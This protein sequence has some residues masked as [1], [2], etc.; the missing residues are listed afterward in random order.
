MKRHLLS[1]AALAA[2]LFAPQLVSAQDAEFANQEYLIVNFATGKY[3]GA[4]NSWGTQ[5]SLVEHPEY[6]KLVPQ[7][8]GTYYLESQVSN[9]GTAHYF[10]GDFMDNDQPKALTIKKHEEPI[11]YLDDAETVPYYGYTISNGTN[12]YGWDGTSTV[13]GKNLN[14]STEEGLSSALWVII[15]L[16]DAKAGLVKASVKEPVDATFLIYD[17][18]FGRNNRWG[19]ELSTHNDQVKNADLGAAW[20]FN[21]S[22]KN[23]AGDATNYCVESWHANFT[24][25]QELKNIPAGVYALTAQGFYRQDGSNDTDL[26]VFYANDATAT[27]PFKTGTENSMDDASHSFSKGLYTID[28]IFVE[29]KDGEALTIGAKLENNTTLWCIWDNFVLTY[30]GACTIEEAKNAATFAQ[31]EEL[32][33]TL[34]GLTGNVE[35]AT[36]KTELQGILDTIDPDEIVTLDDAKKAIDELNVAINK[37]KAYIAMKDKLAQVKAAI[38]TTNFY[39]PEAY[40]ANYTDVLAKYQAGTLTTE[41][42]DNYDPGSREA[43]A[44]PAILLSAWDGFYMNTWSTEGVPGAWNYNGVEFPCPF[45]EYWVADD[46]SLGAKTFTGTMNNIPAGFYNVTL[47]ARVRMKN[48][49]EAPATGIT[50]QVNEGEKI[51][52]CAGD[53]IGSGPFYQKE[54]TATGEVG[55]DGVLKVKIDVADGN[56]ISWLA[57]EKVNYAEAVFDI[58]ISPK[59]GDIA[60]ALTAAA[61]G[62]KVGN[63]TVNLTQGETYTLSS[64]I[65]AAANVIINGNGATINASTLSAP[66]IS[67]KSIEGDFA[68]KNETTPSA[69]VIVNKILIEGVT[70]TGLANSIIDNASG[71]KTLFKEVLLNN[72][73]IELSGSKNVFAL[74]TAYATN[75][76]IKNSTLWSKDGH[77][78]FFFKAD[79]KPADVNAEETTTWAIESSTLYNIAVGKKANNSNGGIKGKKTTYMSITNSLLYNFGSSTG[80]EVNGWLWGQNGGANATYANNAYLNADGVVAGWTDEAKGGSDQ[81]GTSVAGIVT[82]TDAAAGNFNGT[83]E[84][85]EGAEAPQELGDPR[86]KFNITTG[87]QTV[88]TTMENGAYYDLQGRRVAQPVKGLYIVN[89][90]KVVLK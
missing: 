10:N 21:A 64:S 87:I 34:N 63:I 14:I 18:N 42:A 56:N 19:K 80:N 12:Y 51:D 16:A 90:K 44:M 46:N 27:F 65:P 7:D 69:Y 70:I 9:G 75:F 20:T 31:V 8:D 86:W 49:A 85:P 41:E 17:A 83:L 36:V 37:G 35:I 79:G 72:D 53:V 67:Y 82:F 39:T 23:V 32:W 57:F 60:E 22:N 4:G 50:M 55:E 3:W 71:V 89:G 47:L 52:L 62:K 66:F 88:T 61:A 25:S 59:S 24:M 28:P 15:S 84:L 68:M 43:G 5:A 33:N 11:G 13:L 48:N 2:M 58:E 30:Y 76:T 78:G 26:P 74:G 45:Y 81:S 73:V 77:T 1:F 29:V 6:V 40:A 54:F 38:E